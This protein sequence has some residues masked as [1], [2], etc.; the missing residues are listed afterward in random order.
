MENLGQLCDPAGKGPRPHLPLGRPH[1][2]RCCEPRG[3]ELRWGLFWPRCRRGREAR[4]GRPPP[5]P[6]VCS[7][8]PPSR[9]G[10]A[11]GATG[12][13][14]MQFVS[15]WTEAHG[16]MT[17]NHQRLFLSPLVKDNYLLLTMLLLCPPGFAALGAEQGW[18]PQ[19]IGVDGLG[20]P[21]T[22]SCTGEGPL[23]TGRLAEVQGGGT[24]G[25]PSWPWKCR[26]PGSLMGAVGSTWPDCWEL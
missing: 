18:W 1:A 4:G 14:T 5:R 3:R 15:Y 13:G 11:G 10:E 25:P 8:M 12:A 23:D 22:S 9:R 7:R 19:A 26:P 2:G 16:L 20:R 6:P 24:I 21:L 17:Q